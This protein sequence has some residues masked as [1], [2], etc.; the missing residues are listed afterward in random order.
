MS[1]TARVASV[2]GY[3]CDT[4]GSGRRHLRSV[5]GR[6]RIAEGLMQGCEVSRCRIC[7]VAYDN[8]LLYIRIIV[9][10]PVHV[11]TGVVPLQGAQLLK[12]FEHVNIAMSALE[13]FKGGTA[14]NANV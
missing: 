2:G 10:G 5:C 11:T 12:C 13:G 8:N 6:G 4:I 9:T 7:P 3:S 1:F 14:R